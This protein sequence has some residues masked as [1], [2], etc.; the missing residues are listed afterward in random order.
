MGLVPPSFHPLPH[1]QLRAMEGK[2]GVQGIEG[3]VLY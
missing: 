2:L 1:G 3:V